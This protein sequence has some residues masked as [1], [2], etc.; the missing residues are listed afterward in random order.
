M[1]TP[2][3]GDTGAGEARGVFGATLSPLDSVNDMR[4]AAKWMLAAAGAVGAVLISG[5]PLVA[6]GRVHGGLHVVIAVLGLVIAI[7]GV[8]VAIWFTSDVLVPRLTTPA[9]LQ[10]AKELEDLRQLIKAEPAEFFGVAASSLDELF[11][12]QEAL[13]QNAASLA[14]QASRERDPDRHALL[15]AHLIRV[16]ASGERAGRY[17][18]WVL[19]LG[20]AWRIKAALQQARLGTLAGAGLVIAGAVLFFTSAGSN[21]A[22]YVPV[23]TTTPAASASPTAT[24]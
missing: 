21:G 15:Q 12:R 10:R 16:Q 19:A 7:G 23:M 22:E 20:H 11:Q 13:L 6:I 3:G 14:G 2:A 4:S 5:A 18:Q 9:T 8:G 1:T 17:V 24:P